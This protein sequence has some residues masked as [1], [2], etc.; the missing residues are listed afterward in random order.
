MRTA[1]ANVR[2][3][4]Y[5]VVA[6]RPWNRLVFRQIL[7]RYPGRWF[8]V[9][10]PR[11]LTARHVAS[12]GPRYIFLLHWSWRVPSGLTR[13][14]E[15]VGFHMTD[16][17]YG[18]GGSPLQHLILRGHNATT[19]TAFRVGEALDAGPVYL[20]RRLLLHGRAEA[21][22]LRASRLAARMIRT[23]ITQPIQPLPQRGRTTMF[24]RRHP[25]QS[26]LSGCRSLPQLFDHIR[27]L[28]ADGYPRAFLLHRGFRYELSR[29]TYSGR[30]LTAHVTVTRSRPGRSS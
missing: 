19:L 30:R 18:R 15:C 26:D 13:R 4:A 29:A 16:L 8:F 22:Y 11:R 28:D 20:R 24:V 5:L 10:R 3:T 27:M 14:Y 12:I 9:D 2:R 17:P 25:R 23:L 21:I 1:R 7:A 6:S